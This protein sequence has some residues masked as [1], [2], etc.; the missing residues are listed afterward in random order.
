MRRRMV[1]AAAAVLAGLLVSSCSSD[2][3]YSIPL[4]GGA[5]VGSDPMHIDI[6]FDDVLDLVPQSAVK[7]EGVPV[8]RVQDITLAEDGWTANVSTVVN[9]S[10]DL[11]AN[12]L[13]EVRQSNLLGEKFIEL[14]APEGDTSGPRLADGAVIPLTNTRHATEVEQV[15]G[16]LSLLLNGGGVAQLQPIVSELNKALGG[17]EDRVRAVLEQANTLIGGLE[18]QVDDITRALDGLETL[19]NRV[20]AQTNQLTRILDELP[21]GI[22]ILEE[23]RPQLIALLAQLDRVGRAGFDVI[24]TAKDDL[25]RDLRALRPAL[26]EL[27]RAA[28]DLVTALPLVPTYPFPDSTLEGTFGGQVNTWLSVDQQIGVTLSNLGVGK[29]DPVYIPPIGPPVNVDPSNPYYGGN[30]PRPGWP[31]VSL[32]PLP[33]TMAAV[34]VPGQPGVPGLP[35]QLGPLLQPF[36]GGPR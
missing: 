23:Q 31:T 32:F 10:V 8:G 25:I 21:E 29:P 20:A 12:A 9:S 16:A 27:G 19:S 17:R 30:G 33:P 22:R 6:R 4:P 3:I 5:D 1:V 28:P 14:S 2:G 7:V 11:P 36:G 18:D 15:L 34:P 13:A 26:Q 35:P 24:D